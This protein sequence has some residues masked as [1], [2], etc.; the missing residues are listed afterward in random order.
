MEVY[1]S[2]VIKEVQRAYKH[3][4]WPMPETFIASLLLDA[5]RSSAEYAQAYAQMDA[6][7]HGQEPV[8]MAPVPIISPFAQMSLM[9]T[10]EEESA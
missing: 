1:E 8:K 4:A 9:A 3:Q 6:E 5:M 2:G 10:Q 7:G